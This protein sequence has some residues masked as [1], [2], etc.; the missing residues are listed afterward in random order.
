[1]NHEENICYWIDWIAIDY[2]IVFAYNSPVANIP[3]LKSENM[4]EQRYWLR[5]LPKIWNIPEY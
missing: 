3:L 4:E 1:M 2:A 5:D